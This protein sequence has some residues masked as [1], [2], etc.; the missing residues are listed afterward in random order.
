ML[1]IPL[2]IA[3]MATT[4]P[5]SRPRVLLEENFKNL[6]NWQLEGLKEGASITPAGELR[7]DCKSKMGMHGVMAFHKQ[8]LPDN[9]AIEYDFLVEQHNGLFITFIAMT[10]LKGGDALKVDPPRSGVFEDYY[11]GTRSYHVS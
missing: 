10:D 1:L 4:T 6:D 8:D 7:L 2:L 5:T 11:D 9:V 3:A